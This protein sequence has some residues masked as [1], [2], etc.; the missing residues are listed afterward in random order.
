[1]FFVL[2]K[3]FAF[4]TLPFSWILIAL[5][6]SWITK[7]EKLKRYTFRGGVIALLFFSNTVIFCEFTR[8][9]EVEGKKIEDVG[10]YDCAVVLGGMADWDNTNKRLS[11]RRGGDRIWQAINLY[12]LGKVKKI[13]ISGSN[14]YLMED[15][16]DEST[17]FK[18]VLVENGI[19]EED[20]LVENTSKNTYQNA[21]ESKKIIDQHPEINTV[22]LVTSALHMRRSKACFE[23]AGFE[24]FDTFPTDHYTGSRNYKFDQFIVPNVS[25]MNDWE[26]LIHEWIGYVSYAISGYI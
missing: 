18:R 17:Q 1:M 16:L 6:V 15:E 26:R 22:L 11:I 23:K 8:L 12:H 19:P 14:G 5:L 13:I 3:L 10:Y 4:L 25:V 9:W 7:R 20:I 21:V 2:S 24:K